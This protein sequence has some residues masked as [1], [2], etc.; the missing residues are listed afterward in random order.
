[1]APTAGLAQ[2]RPRAPAVRPVQLLRAAVAHF[3]STTVSRF[4]HFANALTLM[5]CA[6]LSAAFVAYPSRDIATQCT[7]GQWIALLR[8]GVR[9]WS[10]RSRDERVP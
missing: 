6:R 1:M 10:R 3:L 4:L 9:A 7:A 5:P 8:L 2:A